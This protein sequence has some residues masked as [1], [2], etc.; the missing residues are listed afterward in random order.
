MTGFETQDGMRTF[1][2]DDRNAWR[3]W[4]SEHHL[5]D[6]EIWFVF[7]TKAADEA[8]VTYNDAVAEV[9]CFG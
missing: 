8:S 1:R 2:T 6:D 9:L 5:T 4:L 3:A 7:P